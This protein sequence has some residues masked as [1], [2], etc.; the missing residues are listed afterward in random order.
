MTAATEL[1][2]PA[3]VVLEHRPWWRGRL[4][5]TAAIVGGMVVCYFAL[6]AQYPWPSWL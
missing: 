6:K 1:A 4:V 5:W 3:P 2:A